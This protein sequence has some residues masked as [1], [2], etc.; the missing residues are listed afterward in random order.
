MHKNILF[1]LRIRG[2]LIK[3]FFVSALLFAF[4]GD[5]CPQDLSIA[6]MRIN[7]VRCHIIGQDIYCYIL[8]DG[9]SPKIW[10]RAT[11]GGLINSNDL[12]LLRIDFKP[13][14][15]KRI[16]Q[17]RLANKKGEEKKYTV[18][19]NLLPLM[20]GWYDNLAG[21]KNLAVFQE[22][23][24]DTVFVYVDQKANDLS[25][26]NYLDE[27]GARGINVILQVRREYI[28]KKDFNAIRSFV[29]KYKDHP[30]VLAWYL[31]DEPDQSLR[32]NGTP[33]P[34]MLEAAREAIMEEDPEKPVFLCF[35]SYKNRQAYAYDFIRSYDVYMFDNYPCQLNEEEFYKHRFLFFS[36]LVQFGR[37]FVI[38]NYKAGFIFVTQAYG[39][40][41]E[42]RS[43]FQKRDPTINEYRYLVFT[44]L[45][46]KPLGIINWTFYRSTRE[47]REKVIYPVNRQYKSL[48]PFA[49][50]GEFMS[51]KAVITP[52]VLKY[53][54]GEYDG[55]VCLI[56]VNESKESTAGSF[57]VRASVIT[58][59]FE[60][61]NI[62]IRG[63][64]FYDVFEPYQVK[65]Y[66]WKK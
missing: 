56:V 12:M 41:N 65:V 15:R 43:Q 55:N 25:I 44:N 51:Q 17:I 66:L 35:G 45:I 22:L 8:N 49:V 2:F 4:T 28:E 38:K 16:L 3:L 9:Q 59:I 19:I 53:N 46:R 30:A 10:Y 47:L 18:H 11:S 6:E 42:G 39:F 50:R 40:D 57:S 24:Y 1:D 26:E 36:G 60:D 48:L 54:L 29:N 7:G 52:A 23:G 13:S 61:R 32:K 64:S 62:L 33:T 5:A 63:G 37:D 27:A 14:E 21:I 31:Y 34:K 20:N 58:D